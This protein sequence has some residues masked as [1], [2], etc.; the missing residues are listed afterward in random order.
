MEGQINFASD[1]TYNLGAEVFDTM[2]VV[3]PDDDL[4]GTSPGGGTIPNLEGGLNNKKTAAKSGSGTTSKK[5]KQLFNH[6]HQQQELEK[7]AEMF[8]QGYQLGVKHQL[9]QEVVTDPSGG[10]G[11]PASST[12]A[13]GVAAAAAGASPVRVDLDSATDSN[14]DTALT[15]ACAGGHD[16]LVRLLLSK[17]ADIGK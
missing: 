15:L 13:P 12:G 6:P 9:A 4:S 8:V 1:L 16:E 14:H 2:A 3:G 10:S 5:C 7:Q 17:G 11:F